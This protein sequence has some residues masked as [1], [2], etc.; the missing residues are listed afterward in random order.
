MSVRRLDV[1]SVSAIGQQRLPPKRD[2][3]ETTEY[4]PE[5]HAI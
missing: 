4:G 1:V 3:S 2:P 5:T